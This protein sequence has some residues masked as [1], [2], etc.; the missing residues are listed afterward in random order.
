MR[1]DDK[2]AL[3]R[4]LYGTKGVWAT[5]FT[6]ALYVLS[7]VATEDVWYSE[8]LRRIWPVARGQPP[9]SL[10]FFLPTS[11]AP[12]ASPVKTTE[13]TPAIANRRSAQIQKPITSQL[14]I[15]A[16]AFYRYIIHLLLSEFA[17]FSLIFVRCTPRKKTCSTASI[18]SNFPPRR[19]DQIQNHLT[20]KL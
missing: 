3:P 15:G 20:E 5:Q 7:R 8:V 4:N 12:T 9:F 19:A 1:E 17:R 18:P 10:V 2:H 11:L 14:K 6:M 13:L 16:L